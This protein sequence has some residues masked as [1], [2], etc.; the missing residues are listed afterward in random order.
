M[1]LHEACDRPH[2]PIAACSLEVGG[3]YCQVLAKHTALAHVTSVPAF[4]KPTDAV[5]NS[6]CV[7]M[8]GIKFVHICCD[9][10]ASFFKTKPVIADRD[11]KTVCSCYDRPIR[12]FI[13]WA[14]SGATSKLILCRRLTIKTSLHRN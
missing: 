12:L 2:V 10:F 6:Q 8:E 4:K 5:I 1:N 3:I 14:I 7:C 13:Y 11:I 9:V